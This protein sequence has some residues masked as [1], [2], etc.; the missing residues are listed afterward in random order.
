MAGHE[1]VPAL[2][3]SKAPDDDL[4]QHQQRRIRQ[5]TRLHLHGPLPF[6]N[7]R[8]RVLIPFLAVHP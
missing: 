6:V 8:H 3:I 2:H 1:P 5:I 7:N 4:I